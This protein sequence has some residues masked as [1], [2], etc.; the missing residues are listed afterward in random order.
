MLPS[1]SLS[2]VPVI[3]TDQMIEVDRIMVADLGIDLVR[4][5]ENAGRGLA[6]VARGVADRKDVRR[7][8]ALA[9]SGGNGGG[10][11]VAARRLAGWGFD[12]DVFTSRPVD[13]SRGVAAEQLAILTKLGVEIHDSQTPSLP[14]A[15]AIILDGL[16]G[17][18]L[19]GAPTGRVGDLIGWANDAGRPIMSLDIPSGI[20]ASSGEAPGVAIKA[21]ATM[22]LALPKMGLV[23]ADA[24]PFVGDLYLADIGVPASVYADALGI[25]V[26][27]VFDRGDVVRLT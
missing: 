6:L 23:S 12:V 21:A 26:G 22:T 2:R 3:S 27:S 18:R 16:V 7:I 24:A 13:A 5:M 1:I 11:L 9:G 4:M 17:Y 8:V 15:D 25:D 10:A 19:S 20:D 14:F